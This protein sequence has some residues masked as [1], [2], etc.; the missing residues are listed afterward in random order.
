MSLLILDIGIIYDTTIRYYIRATNE[1]KSKNNEADKY[2]TSIYFYERQLEMTTN[3]MSI[4][5]F[6]L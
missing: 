5:I 4:T 6:C 1:Q 2:C 3:L